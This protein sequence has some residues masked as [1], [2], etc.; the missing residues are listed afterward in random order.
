[1][2]LH[3]EEFNVE[4]LH[5]AYGDNPVTTRLEVRRDPL[6]GHTARVLPRSGLMVPQRYDLTSLADETRA[7]CPFCSERIDAAV[8]RFPPRIVPEGEAVGREEA[9][10]AVGITRELAAFHLD[11][12]LEEGLLDVEYRRLSGRTGPGAG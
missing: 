4:I 12:L 11:K 10:Q 8:P 6:T 2:E 7:H 1:V 9:T 5:P 3:A